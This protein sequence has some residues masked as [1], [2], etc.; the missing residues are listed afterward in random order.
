M[1]RPRPRVL[2]VDDSAMSRTALTEALTAGGC[3]VVGAAADGGQAI[4]MVLERNPDV[5]TCDLEMPKMDGY[6]FLRIVTQQRAVPVIVVTSNARPE[7]A[8]QALELGARD[9]VVKPA[10]G[11]ALVADIGA[12]L[13]ARIMALADPGKR[14][15]TWSAAEEVGTIHGLRAVV[16]GASTGGPRALRDVLSRLDGPPRVPILIAQHMPPKFTTAFADR[17]A[18]ISGLDVAEARSGER[19]EAGKIRVAP[20]SAHL[21]VWSDGEAERIRLMSPTP[22]DRHVPSVNALFASAARVYKDQVLGIVLTG[23]GRD[24]SEGAA[25]MADMGC[26]MWVE[27]PDTAVIDGMPNAAGAA[28]GAATS[29]SIDRIAGLLSEVAGTA[30]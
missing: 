25:K 5:V 21:E 15:P 29:L 6:T 2:V 20:G 27:S 23:M 16:I 13:V 12:Q 30:D 14:E 4:R 9:F 7:A 28:H 19:V 22:G 18:R 24:G 17:L 11:E 10:G 3:D 8:I 26:P 1:S